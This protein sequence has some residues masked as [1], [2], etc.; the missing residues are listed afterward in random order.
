MATIEPT[1]KDV[2]SK[3]NGAAWLVTWGPLANGDVGDPVQ[4]P[5]FADK[6]VQV[7]GTFG[8]GGSVAVEGDNEPYTSYTAANF[9]A[10]RDPSS[11]T[12]AITAAGAKAVLENTV[13]VRP[14]VTAGDGTTSLTVRMLFHLPHPLRT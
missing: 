11:T 12:I 14:H 13:L 8:T 2:T 5:E 4:M 3:I 1:I 6:S 7:T 10:L 9:V